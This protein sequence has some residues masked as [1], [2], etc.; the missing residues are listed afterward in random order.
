MLTFGG[1]NLFWNF[2]YPS[3]HLLFYSIQSQTRW[4]TYYGRS[5]NVYYIFLIELN[6]FSFSPC[7]NISYKS[8]DW[9]GYG[10]VSLK[11]IFS[12]VKYPE[13]MC[14]LI[15]FFEVIILTCSTRK[16]NE[17]LSWLSHGKFAYQEKARYESIVHGI[18]FS[19]ADNEYKTSSSGSTATVC[20]L[21]NSVNLFIG[22]VG[23]SRVILCRS[24]EPRKLTQDHVPSLIMEKVSNWTSLLLH[25]FVLW[26]IFSCA[27]FSP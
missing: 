7:C 12:L 9:K 3:I 2:C 1:V 23:D 24:G 26:H 19:F 13:I 21:Q 25:Q 11:K 18:S 6:S 15:F 27:Y 4:Y 17:L 5:S 8:R 16:N 22:H 14:C 10:W 20:L